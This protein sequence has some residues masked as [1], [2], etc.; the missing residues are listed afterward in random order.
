M[1]QKTKAILLIAH[2][3]PRNE[4]NDFVIKLS[5]DIE[6]LA[7]TTVQPAFLSGNPISIDEAAAQ[8]VKKKFLSITILP[9]FLAPGLHLQDDIPR[10][11]NEL[12][13]KY[14]QI[15][16]NCMEALG[17]WH[18]LKELIASRIKTK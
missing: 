13:N 12:K 6:E 7:S 14:P 1:D 15:T 18:E 5:T 3:S 17:S 11:L 10:I 4:A 8:L 2:G 9:F 16:I